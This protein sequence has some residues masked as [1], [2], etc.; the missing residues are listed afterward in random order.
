MK[1]K[2][3]G[4]GCCCRKAGA[5]GLMPDRGD[6]AC[7]HLGENNQCKIYETRPDVCNLDKMYLKWKKQYPELTK[8]EY[9]RV[10]GTLCN[11]MMDEF[12]VPQEK[13]IDLSIYDKKS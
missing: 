8:R 1:F 3:S 2:C 11:R 6:G 13:R 4:C 5:L 12:G 10:T 7:V 9:F